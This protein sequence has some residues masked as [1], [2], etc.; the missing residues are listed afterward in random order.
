MIDGEY[1]GQTKTSAEL[2]RKT[3]R[4]VSYVWCSC[5]GCGSRKWTR[6]EYSNENDSKT[7]CRQC[8]NEKNKSRRTEYS[9]RKTPAGYISIW[10]PKDDPLYCMLHRKGRDGGSISEHRYVM[11]QHLGRPLMKWETVHH[12]NGNRADNNLENLELWMKPHPYGVKVEDVVVEYLAG[13]SDAEVWQIV[14]RARAAFNTA[15]MR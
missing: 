10:I 15:K 5:P 6:L 7:L 1:L 11:S 13:L 8:V 4:S 2:G 14:K 3:K 9:R 12:K